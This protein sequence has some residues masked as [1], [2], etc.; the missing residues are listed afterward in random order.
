MEEIKD[1]AAEEKETPIPASEP[2]KVQEEITKVD[3]EIKRKE[4]HLANLNKAIAEENERIRVAR[5]TRRQ[6]VQAKEE[7]LPRIDLDDPSAKAWDNRIREYNDPI[8]AEL[9]A[10]KTEVRTFA[11]QKF[12]ADKP[13]LA[14]KPAKVKEL[15]GLYE[16]M[17]TA[18]ERTSEG[19]LL[20]LNKAYAALHADELIAAAKNQRIEK[21][22]ADSIFADIAVSRGASAGQQPQKKPS[23]K[24][25][26]KE[27]ELIL[28][29]WGS[30]P[31]EWKA[32]FEKHGSK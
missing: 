21:A 16:R 14:S 22:E 18:T 24:V 10:E 3:E 7:E 31:E 13:S 12:L 2:E 5:L 20:D 25:L 19:V 8:K 1:I 30:T 23:P 6:E 28:A 17:R 9:E 15:I 27:D 26:T 11:I 32:D 29:R 4:E